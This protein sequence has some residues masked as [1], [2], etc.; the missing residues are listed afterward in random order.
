MCCVLIVSA[1]D[2]QAQLVLADGIP[3][4]IQKLAGAESEDAAG[5][6]GA[7]AENG[8]QQHSPF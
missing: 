6:L 4:I 1:V 7:L 3:T 2:A 5:A 8:M